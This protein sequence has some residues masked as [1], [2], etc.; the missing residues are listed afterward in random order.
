MN[1]SKAHIQLLPIPINEFI[2]RAYF[3]TLTRELVDRRRQLHQ[4]V[5]ANF[6]LMNQ[7]KDQLGEIRREPTP[8]SRS[9]NSPSLDGYHGCQRHKA[10]PER[11]TLTIRSS[12]I[13]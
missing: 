4:H 6:E 5:Q 13:R 7:M 3:Q 10:A 12:P 11:I 8:Y 9:E 2:T 1:L